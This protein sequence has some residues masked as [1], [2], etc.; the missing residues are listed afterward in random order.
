M[1]RKTSLFVITM[2]ALCLA[3]NAHAK[4]AKTTLTTGITYAISMADGSGLSPS[5]SHGV[6]VLKPLEG[7]WSLYSELG[8]GTGLSAFQPAPKVMAGGSRKITDNLS[9]GCLG[10]YSYT[11]DY[12][13][14][15]KSL[16]AVTGG[17]IIKTKSGVSIVLPV[18]PAYNITAKAWAF[19]GTVK[20]SFAL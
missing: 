17:P 15:S 7:G 6:G 9:L 13:S 18:G 2:V 3:G 20:L 8:F 5:L 10:V 12:G 11:P 1:F 4:P 14:G 16:V 19:S